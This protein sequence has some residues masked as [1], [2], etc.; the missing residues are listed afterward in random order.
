MVAAREAIEKF[1]T[2][3]SPKIIKDW[4]GNICLVVFTSDIS[5]TFTNEWGM[6]ISN[7]NATWTEIGDAESQ[8]DLQDS[9]LINIG[10]V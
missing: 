1:L 10:G 2:N 5:L 7:F 6:G 8:H 3:K 9:G 4:N